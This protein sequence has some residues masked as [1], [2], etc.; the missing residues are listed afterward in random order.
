MATQYKEHT[1]QFFIQFTRISHGILQFY[2]DVSS[3]I[4]VGSHINST[5]MKVIAALDYFR[6]KFHRR[7]LLVA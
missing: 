3:Q 4:Y 1:S 7:Y 6:I 2:L 5:T